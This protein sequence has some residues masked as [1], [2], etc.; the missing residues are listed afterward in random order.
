MMP[1]T[2]T[3]RKRTTSLRPMTNGLADLTFWSARY[4]GAFLAQ[5]P[6]ACAP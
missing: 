2:P 4:S 3:G 6:K 1:T 5:K